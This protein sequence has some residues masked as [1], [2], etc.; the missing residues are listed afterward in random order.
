MGD[1]GYVVFVI[2]GRVYRGFIEYRV[3]FVKFL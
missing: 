3:Y 1:D 2:Y